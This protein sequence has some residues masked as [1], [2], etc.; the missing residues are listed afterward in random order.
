MKAY[1]LAASL[2]ALPFVQSAS[3][4]TIVN[5][6]FEQGTVTNP[7]GFDTLGDT[8]G[9]LSTDLTGWS[10]GGSIDHIGSY[11]Q[12]ANGSNQ[13]LDMSGGDAGSISQTVS[14]LMIGQL[15]EI[16][17][18]LAGNPD[19]GPDPKTLEVSMTPSIGMATSYDFFVGGAMP[20]THA[21]MYWEH[22]IFSFVAS[23]TSAVLKF[24]S[25]T[26]TPYGPALDNV[27]IQTVVPVPAGAP[28]LI[29]GLALL[30]ALRRRRRAA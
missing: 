19:G 28:L 9:L 2:A 20:A 8:F 1:I 22:N 6:D 24:A 29:G 10:I 30:G 14:G 7:G 4:A 27:G 11:W 15:Y 3:A 25:L 26:H 21:N 23:S 12:A 13:S 16:F 17:F 18:D 5:G